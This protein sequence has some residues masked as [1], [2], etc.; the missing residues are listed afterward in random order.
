[1]QTPKL[2]CLIPLLFASCAT[3]TG[4]V[5]HDRAARITNEVGKQ[6]F[7]AIVSY[8]LNRGQRYLTGQNGQ[9]AAEGA[10][11][12]AKQSALTSIDLGRIIDA[13]AGPEVATIAQIEFEDAA[14]RTPAEKSYIANVIG[15]GLQLA[16]NQ[17]AK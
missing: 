10:F 5:R 17:L 6:V 2:I 8:G 11:E 7:S 13:Y 16:A 4:N 3:D 12:A 14:P 15:A 1:M 9:D